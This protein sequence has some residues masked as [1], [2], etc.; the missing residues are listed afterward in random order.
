MNC[1]I[2]KVWKEIHY[3]IWTRAKRGE[4]NSREQHLEAILD[5]WDKI[6]F[7]PAVR[8]GRNWIGINGYVA[9]WGQVCR[10]VVAEDGFDT[11]YM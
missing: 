2:E 6:E 1:P 4:I 7:E 8:D 9:K 10:E 11:K 3:R 5:E